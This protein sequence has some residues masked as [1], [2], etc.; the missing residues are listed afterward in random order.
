M[1][2]GMALSAAIRRY[3]LFWMIFLAAFATAQSHTLDEDDLVIG[4]RAGGYVIVMRHASS[5]R[6]PPDPG[7]A[8]PDNIQLERQLDEPGRASARAMGAA[9]RR[10][11]IPIGRVLSSPT[12]RALQTVRLAQ[13][14]PP[15][16]YVQLGDAGQSMRPD[17]TGA[18]A[19][20]LRAKVAEHPAAGTNT[21]IVTH[22]PN[23]NEAFADAAAGLGDGEALV[24]HPD[25]HGAA[26]FVGRVK[27]E[28]WPRLAS[29]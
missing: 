26:S 5:P 8:D 22:F 13:L 27:I 23:I 12:F 16:T 29:K 19:V 21:F 18:R 17:A 28:D 4:L 9:L 20:W 3:S 1:S 11:R 7:Q 25:G 15:K 14:A 2:D 6:T 10:L 24:F